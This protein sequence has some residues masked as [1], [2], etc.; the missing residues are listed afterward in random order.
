M[1]TAV[2]CLT[3]SLRVC[4][5]VCAVTHRHP[6]WLA[7]QIASLDVISGGRVVCGLGAGWNAEEHRGF[8][9]RFPAV[10]ERIARLE[11]AL[12]LL[13]V[14]WTEERPVFEGRFYR[15]DRPV[16][17]RPIQQPHPPILVGGRGHRLLRVVAR[18]ANIWN[19][20]WDD[21]DFPLEEGVRRLQNACR[22]VGR[23]PNEIEVAPAYTVYIGETQRDVE[24]TRAS[25]A[26]K[27][28][29]EPE[30]L[31]AKLAGA[32][33]GTPEQ[34]IERLKASSQAGAGSAFLLFRGEGPLERMRLF[35]RDVLPAFAPGKAITKHEGR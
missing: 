35:A 33:S 28:N 23:P 27:Q 12:R 29:L 19:P 9:L 21:F 25:D 24:D 14:L 4:P 31:K 11:E 30:E 26:R 1:L 20:G 18:H 7:Y 32:I 6:P 10:G 5:L 17:P 15:A 2:A 3:K 8:G 16:I 22:E 13:K 34:V